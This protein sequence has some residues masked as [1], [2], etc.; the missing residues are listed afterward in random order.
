MNDNIS[1]S[2][3]TFNSMDA[4]GE[5]II[6]APDT[7]ANK[8][9][10]TNWLEGIPGTENLCDVVEVRFKNTRKG[11]YANVNKLPLS[12]GD[13]VAVEA[14][15]GHDIGVVSLVGPLV[16]LQMKKNGVNEPEAALKKIY[17]KAKPVDFEKWYQAVALE[18]DTMLRARQLAASL[19]LSMKISDVE[20]QGDKTK[21]IFYYISDDRVDFRELIKLYADAFKV[22]IEMKQI[23][24][25]QEAGRV[26][27]IGSCGRALCCASWMSNF[28]SVSTSAAR[29]QDISL[30]PQKLAGQCGKL[31]CCLNYELKSYVD[32]QKE[33]PSTSVVLE[34]EAGPAYHRKT[35]VFRRLM[36]YSYRKDAEATDLIP[37]DV[38]TVKEIIAMNKKGIKAPELISSLVDENEELGYLNA[39]GEDSISRFEEKR[40]KKK[41]KKRGPEASAGDRSARPAGQNGPS[42]NAGGAPSDGRRGGPQPQRGDSRPNGNRSRHKGPRPGGPNGQGGQNRPNNPNGQ[43]RQRNAGGQNGQN[44]PAG[45][46]PSQSQQA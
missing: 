17:R 5:N 27:S 30:N 3:G 9:N 31:K 4:S 6:V 35:D 1:E 24:A 19:N 45:T 42:Q 28:V 10:V 14:S 37:L 23:G 22:R 33:Y 36:W 46:P 12:K 39:A 15:P 32:A 7:G 20:Y 8:L 2:R 25:R 43:N 29:Y 26:G 34:T 41:K 40:K 18:H 11:Y 38:D 16:R 21:A 44:R 13:V